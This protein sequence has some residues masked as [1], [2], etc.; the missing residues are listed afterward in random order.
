M[1]VLT[2]M[3]FGILILIT[4]CISCSQPSASIW[5]MDITRVKNNHKAELAFFIQQNWVKFREEAVRDGSIQ[6]YQVL[7]AKQDSTQVTEYIL[8][9]KF[10]DSTSYLAM[11]NNFSRIMKSISPNG[12]ALL[13]EVKP[14]DFREFVYSGIA[15]IKN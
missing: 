12:P 6:G 5:V 7:E 14:N 8:I 2:K 11:E 4:S 10:S 9:T 15:N 3:K 1:H 13:N